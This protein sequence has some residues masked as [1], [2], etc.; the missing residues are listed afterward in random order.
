MFRLANVF[1]AQQTRIDTTSA[2][3]LVTLAAVRLAGRGKI[4]TTA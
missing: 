3:L 2:H 1:Q 4:H